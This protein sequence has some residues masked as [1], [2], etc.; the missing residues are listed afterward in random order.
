MLKYIFLNPVFFLLLWVPGLYAQHQ[1][2]GI[3]SDRETGDLLPS[4]TILYEGTMRGTIANLEGEFSIQIDQYPAVLVI[5]YIGY[6]SARI[7][8][9]EPPEKQLNVELKPSVTEMEEIVVTDRDPGLTIMEKVIERKKIWR[10]NLQTYEVDAYTRQVLQNDTSIVSILESKT[11]SF[12]DSEMGHREIQLY[13]RETS[14]INEDQ[15]F[16]GVR[17]LPNFY[18]DNIEIAGF[19]VVGITHPNALDFYEFTLLET[20]QVDGKPVYKIDVIPARRLHPLFEG[21]V[22]VLG[23]EYALLEVDLKPNRV[24]NFPPP[25]QDFNLSYQQQFSNYGRDFWLPVD[26]RIDGMIRVA[27]VGLRFPPMHFRQTSR[28]SDY[29]VNV[30]LPDSLFQKD[31]QFTKAEPDSAARI[32]EE[33]IPLTEQEKIAYAT[34]DCTNTLEDSFKPEGFLAKMANTDEDESDGLGLGK[35]LPNGLGFAGRFNR[36]DGFNAGLRYDQHFDNA[37]L[38]GSIFANYSFHSQMTDYGANALKRL[39]GNPGNRELFLKASFATQTEYRFE[40]SMYNRYMNSIQAVVGGTD[41]FDYYHSDHIRGGFEIRRLLP[42]LNVS[43]MINHQ[44]D[45]SVK[46]NAES[47][48]DYSLFG[49]HDKRPLN[50]EIYDG[51]INSLQFRINYNTRTS[52]DFGISGNREFSIGVEHSGEHLSSDF[53]FTNVSITADWNLETFFRRRIF[54][55]ALDFHLEAGHAFGE[56]PP[57]K[58]GAVDGSMSRFTPFGTLKTRNQRPYEG[59]TYWLVTAEHNFRSIPFELLGI[60]GLAD[61]GWGIILFGGAGYAKTDSSDLSYI[62]AVTDGI[63]SEAGISLNSIF[64]VLRLDVAKRI[65]APGT[66]IGFSV[67]RYF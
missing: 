44:K 51:N 37:G 58:F 21:T 19:D 46:T 61:K 64:G 35:I 28:L 24:V 36:A 14:N 18:D 15:N 6:E 66:Y 42:H 43:A 2:E 50:P 41:Y 57:Q 7:E 26:M 38:N 10:A 47:V 62:P 9:D 63:H 25:V 59:D 40:Q 65:D 60:Y 8:L 22:F 67:P 49:W 11:R 45:S 53:N 17:F 27:M 32:T 56:L 20:L 13:Q 4:A 54:S 3:V 30:E 16:A 55:N 48:Y 52:S 23:E 31:E 34:I 39:A 5:R 29:K 12:W 1:I 33:M